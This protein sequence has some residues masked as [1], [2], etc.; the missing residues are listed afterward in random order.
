MALDDAT[1]SQH[2][3]HRGSVDQ[4]FELVEGLDDTQIHSLLEDF[5]NTVTS[6]VP[7]SHGIEFFEHPSS[8][9]RAKTTPT[10]TTTTTTTTEPTRSSSIRKSFNKLPRLFTRSPSKRSASAPIQRPQ[11]GLP[12]ATRHYRRISRPVLPMLS[13]G[14][15]LDALLSAYLSPAPPSTSHK[16]ISPSRSI[17][18]SSTL[19]IEAEDSGVDALAPLVF[20]RPQREESPMGDIMEVLSF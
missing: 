17:S 1:Y 5:N 4:L 15:D 2:L 13:N 20:G 8:V 14:P 3:H 9:V 6:N 16:T 19:S 11:T 12:P 18:S 10:T 7:V